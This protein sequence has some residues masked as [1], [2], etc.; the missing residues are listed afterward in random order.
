V[1]RSRILLILALA[2]AAALLVPQPS[3]AP[4]R[5]DTVE[6]DDAADNSLPHHIATLV[7]DN[8][9][10]MV[11]AVVRH[12]G[13]DWTGS[14][15]LRFDVGGAQGAE[16]V[17]VI[18]RGT[19]VT[20]RFETAGGL[21]W[22][23][24]GLLAA[25]V[26]PGRVTRL[27]APRS[28]LAGA[29]TMMVEAR[30]NAGEDVDTA[31]S[32]VVRQQTRP[33]IVMIMVDDM[34]DD[35]LAY[36]PLTQQLIGQ[37]GVR[38]ANSLAQYPLCCPARASV[39]TG[40]YA[41]NHK[42]WSHKLPWGFSSFDDRSTLATWL[43][44]AGYST[45]YIGKYLNGYGIQPPPRQATGTSVSYVPPG[46]TD[47]RGSIDGGLDKGHPAEGGTYRYMDT[48]LN[49]NG[50]GFDNYAGRYQTRVYGE[51]SEQVVTQRAASDRPFFFY[52]SYTAPHHG[53]PADPDD[54]APVIN[55]EGRTTKFA[56][57]YVPA[58]VRG[59]YD[60]VISEAPGA[61]WFRAALPRDKPEY[62]RDL[63]PM[64]DAEKTALLEVTR[65]RAEALSVVDQQVART[66]RALAA[67]GELEETLVMFTSDNGY[68]LGEQGIRAGK[69]L[70]HDPSLH[71]PLLM[72]GPGIPA[73]EVRYDPFLSIDFAPTI[74][75]LAGVQAGLPMDGTSMLGVARFG[76]QGW[77]RA[78]L[79]E[80][81]RRSI[82]RD[83][84]EAGAP[85]PADDPGA[86]DIRYAIGVRS[87]RY[88]YIHLANGDEELYDMAVDPDQYDNLINVRTYARVRELM[89]DQL[90]QIRACD[91]SQCR[92]LLPPKLRSEPGQS[93]LNP[94]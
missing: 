47:W 65:Q 15:E 39:L 72:R 89:R 49:D 46:W 75:Q 52:V 19:G 43:Q 1:L 58:E 12:R 53:L 23:C 55:S 8:T 83:T 50:V 63:R 94:G 20:D 34:R 67:T 13:P 54:P 11:G 91:A 93:V 18:N 78:V 84:D 79:T 62:L 2:L 36:M 48:T 31:V 27:T 45:T 9:G 21:P 61:S 92:V 17:A 35:D 22:L 88:L 69:T 70:P 4:A 74:T 77:S 14:V 80:T 87:D 85:L 73:G 90:A 68:F 40:Q 86:A 26:Y 59:R 25:S 3:G 57:P 71:T 7:V 44:D 30:A 6:V 66:I 60:G 64:N 24:D 37:Q 81:G 38:F 76:D 16:Y 32:S 29:P 28:C 42:V 10:D 33:N 82:V 51:L 56:S 5:A 41:H